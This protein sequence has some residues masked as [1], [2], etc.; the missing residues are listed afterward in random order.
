MNK[1]RKVNYTELCIPIEED[2]LFNDDQVMIKIGS[3]GMGTVYKTKIIKDS[4]LYKLLPTVVPVNIDIAIKEIPID[5]FSID[6]ILFLQRTTNLKYSCKY[7]CCLFDDSYIYIIMEYIDGIEL[8]DYRNKYINEFVLIETINYNNKVVLYIN[9][10]YK[11]ITQ[12]ALAIEELHNI[13]ILHNDIKLENIMVITDNDNDNDTSN[14]KIKLIDYGFS[15]DFEKDIKIQ[16][17]C[18]TSTGTNGYFINEFINHHINKKNNNKKNN[19]EE[20]IKKKDWWSFGIVLYELLFGPPTDILE[21]TKKIYSLL[22]KSNVPVN[23]HKFH[24]LFSYLILNKKTTILKKD[25]TSD[26]IKKEIFEIL[27][28]RIHNSPVINSF[29][30]PLMFFKRHVKPNFPHVKSP[31]NNISP[32]SNFQ[33]TKGN[34]VKSNFPPKVPIH[35]PRTS[36]KTSVHS[37]KGTN[38]SSSNTNNSSNSSNYSKSYKKQSSIIIPYN[39]KGTQKENP[40]LEPIIEP[41]KYI[42]NGIKVDKIKDVYYEFK[43]GNEIT[44]VP[45]FDISNIIDMDSYSS[46][47][48]LKVKDRI[49]A[50]KYRL[51][52]G[53]KYDDI[54]RRDLTLY[55]YKRA[56]NY[57][58]VPLNVIESLAASQK[59]SGGGKT[60]IMK[61]K[62]KGYTRKNIHNRKH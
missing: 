11:I 38:S 54:V 21:D 20:M 9:N 18:K 47:E 59:K 1:I 42:V 10:V 49:V 50:A 28:L 5:K 2:D 48:P 25:N 7:Y 14:L 32:T 17:N 51:V 31:I 45:E 46:L 30:P 34:Y 6:E 23:S 29:P 60:K 27:G 39:A 53:V 58:Y 37:I 41:T 8:F 43:K 4:K 36:Y 44:Y 33:P 22:D 62:T 13:K 3:G 61:S 56:G 15:C 55:R 35:I 26:I 19:Y 52:S 16:K 24:N 12:L 40:S 57:V